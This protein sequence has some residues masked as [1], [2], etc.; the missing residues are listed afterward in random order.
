MK[1]PK[2]RR[3][4]GI[5]RVFP[6]FFAAVLGLLLSGGCAEP[7]LPARY[8]PV[9]PELPAHW[10]RVL[11]SGAWRLVWIGKTGRLESAFVPRG[12]PLPDVE[13][14][15][16][17]QSMILA[18]PCWPERRLGAET[19]R[20]AGA[21]FPHDAHGGTITLTWEAGVEAYLFLLMAAVTSPAEDAAVLET[22]I[23]AKNRAWN[24]DWPRFRALLAGAD[25]PETVREDPWR[26]DWPYVAQKTI[27]SG[28]DRRRIKVA[29][30]GYTAL[31]ITLPAGGPWFGP[32]PFSA[33]Y[34]WRAGDRV[35]INAGQAV[36]TLIAPGGQMRYGGGVWIWIAHDG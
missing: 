15:Q 24:F 20:P 13:F 28:F 18:W 36:E 11:G 17:R 25:I 19:M 31:E 10:R 16:G 12:A 22:A 32:S 5:G 34:D 14:P 30:V 9:P 26:V 8:R 27:A 33:V 6:V 35:T 23:P 1:Q 21:I 7:V 2:A 29:T 4:A 3:G